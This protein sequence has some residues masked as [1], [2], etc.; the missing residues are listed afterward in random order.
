MAG[1]TQQRDESG[2]ASLFLVGLFLNSL[3]TTQGKIAMDGNFRHIAAWTPLY[4]DP[5]GTNTLSGLFRKP[6]V[7]NTAVNPSPSLFC[8]P[9]A[10]PENPHQPYA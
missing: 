10:T 9:S 6:A 1:R 8:V 7:K 2:F 4:A 3:S 5:N